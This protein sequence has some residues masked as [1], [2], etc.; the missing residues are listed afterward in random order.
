[1]TDHFDATQIGFSAE[2]EVFIKQNNEDNC[3]DTSQHFSAINNQNYQNYQ[4]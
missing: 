4:N 3:K 1:M 2:P